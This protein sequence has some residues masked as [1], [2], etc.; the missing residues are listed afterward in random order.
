MRSRRRSW[1]AAS[2]TGRSRAKLRRSPLTEY[3]RAG[4][5]TFRPDAVVPLPDAEPNQLQPVE[6][7]LGEVQF[8]VGELAGRVA[9]VVAW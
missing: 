4:N 2:T 7:A 8:R 3:W 5:V 6:R 1:L 9:V